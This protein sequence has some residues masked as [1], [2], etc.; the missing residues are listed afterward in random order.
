MLSTSYCLW[1]GRRYSSLSLFHMHTN[2]CI[3]RWLKSKNYI[4]LGTASILLNSLFFSSDSYRRGVTLS[5]IVSQVTSQAACFQVSV[6]KSDFTFLN[7]VFLKE[8]PFVFIHRNQW[9]FTR[10]AQRSMAL[11]RRTSHRHFDLFLSI[12]SLPAVMWLKDTS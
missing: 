3:S 4:V 1:H 11:T 12:A 6:P 7:N 9:C 5:L 8:A 10:A 2:W